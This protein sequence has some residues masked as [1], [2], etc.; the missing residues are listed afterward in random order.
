[1]YRNGGG[2]SWFL[3][4]PVAT[5]PTAE[6]P[7][8]DDA[9]AN[10]DAIAIYDP[11]AVNLAELSPML[12]DDMN[13]TANQPRTLLKQLTV[14]DPAGAGRDNLTIEA[15][16][17]LFIVES[18]IQRDV[19]LGVGPADV[20]PSFVNVDF[21]G[22]VRA[23]LLS[24]QAPG[25]A[26]Y[27]G[28]VRSP[29]KFALVRGGTLDGDLIV[30]GAFQMIGGLFGTVFVDHGDVL[31]VIEGTAGATS[32]GAVSSQVVW[33]GGAVDVEGNARLEF[34]ASANEAQVEFLE[35]GGLLIDGAVTACA[36][37]TAGSGDWKCGIPLT[38]ANLDT[39]M[40]AGGFGGTA[41][42]PG[43]ASISNAAKDL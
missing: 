30:G 20:L 15:N 38:P 21:A 19:D 7:A 29:A 42:N 13:T 3:S 18:S 4:Q 24:G 2:P 34:P 25:V 28:Q 9:W 17:A 40:S 22:T 35:K 5:P 37:D 11:V 36:V 39:S 32:S 26:L 6:Q 23:G 31:S 14:F 27:G 16:S 8:E 33:G 1:V 43:G 10:G 12:A 41:A